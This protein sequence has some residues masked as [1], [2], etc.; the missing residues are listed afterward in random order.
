[1]PTQLDPNEDTRENT[2]FLAWLVDALR[3]ATNLVHYPYDTNDTVYDTRDNV[4]LVDRDP[5]VAELQTLSTWN[6]L[7]NSVKQ[8]LEKQF[9]GK[10]NALGMKM[11]PRIGAET[12]AR[13]FSA[14]AAEQERA[15]QIPLPKIKK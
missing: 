7:P 11:T 8:K 2:E 9:T 6:S 13:H 10:N 12:L 3:Q 5:A 1:M 4:S 15:R 14:V